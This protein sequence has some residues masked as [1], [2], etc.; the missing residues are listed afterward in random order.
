LEELSGFKRKAWT[1]L[2]HEYAPQVSGRKLKVLDIGTGPGFFAIIMAACGY[3]VTAIDY[4]E[5][6]IAMARKNAG[7]Y[8]DSISFRRMDAHA[9]EFADNTFDLIITRNLTWNLEKPGEAYREWFRVL[10]Q[11]G[12]MLNFDANWYGHLY[13]AQKRDEYEQDRLNALQKNWL[14]I[15]PTRTRK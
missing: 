4:T 13:D 7:P 3:T 15:T 9:L 12:R 6:M 8:N 11:G 10:R 2:I 5:A 1:D 14:I